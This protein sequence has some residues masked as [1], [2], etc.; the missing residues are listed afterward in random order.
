[1]NALLILEA[2]ALGVFLGLY[3]VTPSPDT[4][5]LQMRLREVAR[6]SPVPNSLETNSFRDRVLVPLRESVSARLGRLLPER[7]GTAL[8]ERLE[9]AGSPTT[10]G[11]LMG[12]R[13]ILT[14]AGFLPVLLGGRGIIIAMALMLLGWR[15]PDFW[16]GRRITTRQHQ[17]QRGLADVM[18]LLSVSVE[19]GLGF[20]G[21]LARVAENFGPPISSE[22]GRALREIRLGRPRS[23]ALHALE[24]R[25]AIQEL[26]AFV[27]AV[28]QADELGVGLARVLKVQSEQMRTL[29]RQRA[30]EQALKTPIKM[31]FPLI[32]FI[33]PAI[34][35]V[36]LGPAAL[37]FAVTFGRH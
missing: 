31:L 22:F 6:T 2:A 15:L 20:D 3:L 27:S 19:A 7:Q 10:P 9:R 34:F 23:E 11:L 33:F 14:A 1:M 37:S 30:Q 24:T 12:W 29:R 4:L 16:L 28:I 13:I 35:V 17:F 26:S 32:F 36:L 18:D 5:R 8:R 25:M 21:A